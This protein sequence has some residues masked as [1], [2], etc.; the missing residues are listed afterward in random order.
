MRRL[1]ST[2]A[3]LALAGAAAGCGGPD[4]VAVD[5]PVVEIATADYRMSPQAVR[6]DRGRT[7]FRLRNAGTLAHNWVLKRERGD[8][9]RE[10]ARIATIKP[11]ATDEVTVRLRPG[12]YRMVCTVTRHEVLGE[13]GTVEV[14]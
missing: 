3:L 7:T 1:R 12:T 8:E 9:E 13:H 10:L 14:R 5:G 11:G 6:T 2:C 4:P